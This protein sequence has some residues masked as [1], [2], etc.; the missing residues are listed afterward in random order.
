ML[1]GFKY[2]MSGGNDSDPKFLEY[3]IGTLA[4]GTPCEVLETTPLGTKVRI[5][6]GPH[7]RKVGWVPAKMV[8]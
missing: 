7:K 5:L 4:S 8:R 3:T 6:S 1:E 2:L